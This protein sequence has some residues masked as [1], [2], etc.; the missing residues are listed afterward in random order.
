M[1][2]DEISQGWRVAWFCCRYHATAYKGHFY[3]K[4]WRRLPTLRE[5][6]SCVEKVLDDL[7]KDWSESYEGALREGWMGSTDALDTA[8]ATRLNEWREKIEK[9][10]EELRQH[11]G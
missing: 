7:Y 5:A 3:G 1:T 11:V 10:K 9:A 6:V 4:L 2:A 8:V